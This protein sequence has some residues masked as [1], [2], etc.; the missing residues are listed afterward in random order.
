M[1]PFAAAPFS[2]VPIGTYFDV[3]VRWAW[4]TGVTTGTGT[5]GG[6]APGTGI[7][8]A[9]LVTMLWRIAGEPQPTI[10]NPFTDIPAGA[11][12][13]DATTWAFTEGI[14]TGVNRSDRFEPGRAVNRAQAIAMLWRMAGEPQPTGPNPF[15]DIPAGAYF[16]D[17]TT[18]AFTEG[19]TTGV[20]RSDRFAPFE[21]LTRAQLV[22]MLWRSAGS[23]LGIAPQ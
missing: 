9:Q 14:T 22:T 20:N 11:Y 21:D 12:F 15:S 8:R 23:P 13:T 7:P 18:W 10:A 3:A 1:V 19:I 16:A 17:A 6:F 4:A 5:S 2:D